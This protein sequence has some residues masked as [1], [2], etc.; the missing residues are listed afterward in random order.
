[1]LN[2]TET[3]KKSDYVDIEV[4]DRRR[5]CDKKENFELK[6]DLYG[7]ISSQIM[8]FKK[9]ETP[10]NIEIC[11]TYEG[12]EKNYEYKMFSDNHLGKKI[13]FEIYDINMDMNYFGSMEIFVKTLTGRTI[14]IYVDP[15]EY[16]AVTQIKIRDKDGIPPDQQRLVFEGAQLC[17]YRTIFDFIF[18]K[19]LLY[20]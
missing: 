19:V 8:N 17:R 5:F 20:I 10:D 9:Y 11:F 16:I 6:V 13:K 12:N 3:P 4:I 1:M 18:K 2:F 15:F 14:S 7:N